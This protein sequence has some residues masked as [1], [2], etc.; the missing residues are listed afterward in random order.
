MIPDRRTRDG[1]CLKGYHERIFNSIIGGL[2]VEH[3]VG[4]GSL[5]DAGANTGVLSC[6]L[7]SLAPDRLV[8]SIEPLHENVVHIRERYGNL[9]N[10]RVI[11]GGLGKQEEELSFAEGA[12]EQAKADVEGAQVNANWFSKLRSRQR[13]PD[14]AL[15]P[16]SVGPMVSLA[17][18]HERARNVLR[19][20]SIDSLFFD[21]GAR[22]AKE[23]LAFATIDVEGSESDVV[24]GAVE[25]IKRDL[26]ILAL[27]LFVDS[28]DEAAM[29]R[30]TESL[31]Y[32]AFV[33][34][35][36]CGFNLDCRNALFL[37]RAR[38][39]Q[40][41]DSHTLD[42]ATASG[43]LK[44]VNSTTIHTYGKTLSKTRFVID[45]QFR[46]Y[47]EASPNFQ[48]L[49]RNMRTGH[50]FEAVKMVWRD[51]LM[52]LPAEEDEWEEEARRFGTTS[53]E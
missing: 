50:T 19:V 3:L 25:T 42:L 40:F 47:G 6:Y 13:R 17:I 5:L 27:E 35:E 2:F 15:P 14:G 18:G 43:R 26:P 21:H 31:G 7:A 23:R 8:H 48:T 53:R 22:F 46:M 20:H 44:A 38:M 33:V 16:V 34:D 30:L 12:S 9:T 4:P 29:L 24:L 39:T 1:R 52:R 45:R 32:D 49:V 10:I 37:P 51:A 11:H 41:Y 36:T 28:R